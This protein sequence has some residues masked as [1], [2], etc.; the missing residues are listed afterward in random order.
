MIYCGD[1]AAE[2]DDRLD[3][4]GG[5]ISP[6]VGLENLSR[7]VGHNFTEEDLDQPMPLL[8]GDLVGIGASRRHINEM[9]RQRP[10]TVRE[11]Y[12]VFVPTVGHPVFKG[13]PSQ[14]ADT[15]GEWYRE[16]ACDGFLVTLPVMPVDFRVFTERVVPELQARGLFRTDY[17]D[18]GLRD[19]MGV[20]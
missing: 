4:L 1:N 10:M 6:V 20:R 17:P 8:E 3:V 5:L 7:A 19:I 2:I 16:G 13:S 12:Q 9:I 15:M 11:V 14:I 18:G